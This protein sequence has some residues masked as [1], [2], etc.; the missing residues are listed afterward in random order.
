MPCRWADRQIR[1][2]PASF[3]AEAFQAS[4]AA[5]ADAA[6]HAAERLADDGKLTSF[7][8]AATQPVAMLGTTVRNGAFFEPLEDPPARRECVLQRHR[9]EPVPSMLA[10]G[11]TRNF[12]SVCA[13]VHAL[14]ALVITP[15]IFRSACRVEATWEG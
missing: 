8:R 6:T 13:R 3:D 9:S 2:P 5:G 15:R 10:V 12:G 1:L 4:S 14:P 7:R 11:S